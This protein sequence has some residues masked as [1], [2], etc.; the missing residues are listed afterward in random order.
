MMRADGLLLLQAANCNE[1]IPAKAYEYLRCGRP[2]LAL[3]DPVGDTAN[4]LRKAG[5]GSIARLDS[6]EEIADEMAR[7]LGRAR[8]AE[9]LTPATSWVLAASRLERTRDLAG[10]LDRLG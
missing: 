9:A 3:T 6:A 2:I 5:I 8:R 7:F 10:L 1:Q 4:L